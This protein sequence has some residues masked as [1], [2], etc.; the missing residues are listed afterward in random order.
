MGSDSSSSSSST[1][2]SDSTSSSSSSTASK[3]Q[4]N[5]SSPKVNND[6]D[7]QSESNER[8]ASD[9]DVLDECKIF[10]SRIPQT[11]NEE[12]IKRILNETYGEGCVV[13][14]SLVAVKGDD[15]EVGSS[16][17]DKSKVE[18]KGHRGFGFVTFVSK[19][20]YDEAIKAGA[21]R[22]TAKEQSKRKHTMYIQQVVRDECSQDEAAVSQSKSKDICFLWKKFRCPYGDGCKFIHDGE[23]GCVN[24]NEDANTKAK[25]QKCFS[26]KKRGKCK[27][28][29][30]C[31]FSHDIIKKEDSPS[32]ARTAAGSTNEKISSND[33]SSKDC[34]NW[35]TKGKC[36]KR[37]KCPYRH[38]ESVRLAALAK[39]EK[40]ADSNDGLSK[41]KR[42]LQER[43]NKVKCP[44]SIRVFGLNYSTT[45]EDVEEFFRHCGKIMEI[46][47]PTYEDSGRSKGYCGILFAS[48][49]AV[50]KAVEEMNGCELH[51]RW[52]SVQEGKM[53]LRKWEEN[54]KIKRGHGK[55]ID[56]CEVADKEPLIGEYGQ[57]VKK[58]K[59]HGFSE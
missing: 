37:D 23:G 34:I 21:V 6:V 36:R 33:K 30:K 47:F 46:T 59:R 9:E 27:L 48:P 4:I 28:G 57:K 15:G 29:D 13:D 50:Q 51:G 32:E 5:D 44:L 54:E 56:G 41:T 19:D 31:P 40:T 55:Q 8:R 20:I 17:K 16:D 11:F 22:G 24:A 39:K 35:K 45:K 1:S 18:E 3:E 14:V 53:F 58:R 43:E 10:L 12:S 26:F 38:D 52:L 49:K 42:K 25:V 2:S 7:N